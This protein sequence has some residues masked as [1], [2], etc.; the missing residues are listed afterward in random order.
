MSKILEFV[1]GIIYLIGIVVVLFTIISDRNDSKK[2]L[3]EMVS[4]YIKKKHCVWNDRINEIAYI[5]DVIYNNETFKI[6]DKV[7]FDTVQENSYIKM[8][9]I[10]NINEHG[11]PE[12]ILDYN[13]CN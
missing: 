11:E 10:E 8:K 1:T 3:D 12:V 2:S 5:V 7:F 9:L 6:K 4:V 13:D